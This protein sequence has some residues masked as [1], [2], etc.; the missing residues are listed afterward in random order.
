MK[1]GLLHVA[2]DRGGDARLDAAVRLAR[3]FDLHLTGAQA[4]P[5]SAYAMADPFGGVYTNAR[6]D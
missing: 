1:T 4:A 2:E 3:A 5:L 6:W